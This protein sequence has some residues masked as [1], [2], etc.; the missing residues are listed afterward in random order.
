MRRALAAAAGVIVVLAWAEWLDR[1]WSRMLVHEPLGDGQGSEAVVVLGFRNRGRRANLVNRQ[2]VRAGLRS[3]AGDDPRSV[4]VLSGGAP[5]GGPPE[6]RVMAAYA[7]EI[8]YDGPLLTEENSRSTWENVVNVIDIVEDFDRIKIV[9]QPA[10]AL[11]ARAHL[12]ALR[13][14]LAERLAPA[15]DHRLGEWLL[16]KP[17]TALY[18]LWAVRSVRGQIRS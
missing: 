11:K 8:G 5:A 2:R 12:K 6:A 1:R 15:A 3:L 13:P 9:S 4:L 16:V 17:L 14:D 10:H 7:R 18:G